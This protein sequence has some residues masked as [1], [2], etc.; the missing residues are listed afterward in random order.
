MW[1]FRKPLKHTDTQHTNIHS[2]PQLDLRNVRANITQMFHITHTPVTINDDHPHISTPTI[3]I[4]VCFMPLLCSLSQILQ[5]LCVQQYF[6][7]EYQ[8][9]YVKDLVF[10]CFGDITAINV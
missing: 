9:W 6:N 7:K 3:T 4:L 5:Y 10:L 2:A 8:N 1:C